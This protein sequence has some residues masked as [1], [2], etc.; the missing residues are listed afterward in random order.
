MDIFL[1]LNERESQGLVPEALLV[2]T[3]MLTK[4]IPVMK[5]TQ[6]RISIHLE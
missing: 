4:A 1:L 3:K 2:I 5:C 6:M